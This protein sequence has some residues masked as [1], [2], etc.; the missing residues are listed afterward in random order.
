MNIPVA[1]TSPIRANVHTM[2]QSNYVFHQHGKDYIFKPSQWPDVDISSD[3]QSR[4]QN[5]EEMVSVAMSY[6]SK[7]DSLYKNN[8]SSVLK[9][10]NNNQSKEQSEGN[11]F[12]NITLTPTDSNQRETKLV[13]EYSILPKTEQQKWREELGIIPEE[14]TIINTPNLIVNRDNRSSMLNKAKSET[15]MNKGNENLISFWIVL[16]IKIT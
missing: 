2:Q 12:Q 6:Y 7:K 13:K 15:A 10:S 9:N 1:S 8:D 11:P 3:V 4:Y 5:F 14:S 16:S